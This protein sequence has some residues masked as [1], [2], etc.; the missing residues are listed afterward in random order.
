MCQCKVARSTHLSDFGS[1]LSKTG[2][3]TDMVCKDIAILLLRGEYGM[4]NE[5]IRRS[6]RWQLPDML[7]AGSSDSG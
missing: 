1:D 7:L 5:V 3:E 4:S 6:R 2:A